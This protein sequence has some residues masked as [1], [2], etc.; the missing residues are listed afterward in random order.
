[1][2]E[3]LKSWL[4]S[5]NSLTSP[6]GIQQEEVVVNAEAEFDGAEYHVKETGFI[7]PTGI[8]FERSYT[9]QS[10]EEAKDSL[11]ENT[12][13]IVGHKLDQKRLGEYE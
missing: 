4:Y 8:E 13:Q 2:F 3:K 10:A 9:F 12:L 6:K 5:G 1:M 11:S 7:R